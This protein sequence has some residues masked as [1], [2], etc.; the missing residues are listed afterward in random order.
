[1][2]NLLIAAALRDRLLRGDV[3]G[4]ANTYEVITN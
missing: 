4:A 1:M 2:A 3:A